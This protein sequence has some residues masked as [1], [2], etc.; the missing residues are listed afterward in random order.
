MYGLS[1]SQFM[2][3]EAQHPQLLQLA[4]VVI[5]IKMQTEADS[6]S[7]LTTTKADGRSARPQNIPG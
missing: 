4:S 7:A 1:F 3:A 6:S 2:T 5:D